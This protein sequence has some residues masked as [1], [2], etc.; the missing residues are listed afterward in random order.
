MAVKKKSKRKYIAGL[1][2]LNYKVELDWNKE[3]AAKLFSESKTLVPKNTIIYSDCIDGM[4]NMPEESIDLIIADPPFG[5]DFS[6]KESQYNR[7]SEN[8]ID[9]YVEIE[10]SYD[11]FSEKLWIWKMK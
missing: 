9:G 6:G 4:K 2:Q 3:E 11:S 1:A 10:D 7:K 5:I 8:I